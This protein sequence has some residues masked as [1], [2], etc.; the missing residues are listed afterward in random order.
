MLQSAEVLKTATS[1]EL[2]HRCICE[3]YY[4]DKEFADKVLA[5]QSP[6]LITHSALL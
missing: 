6:R 2:L 4:F 5:L 3:L 1:I